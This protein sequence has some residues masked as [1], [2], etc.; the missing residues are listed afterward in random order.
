MAEI[1]QGL[2]KILKIKWKLQTAY[3]PQSSRKVECMN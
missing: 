2:A 3:R 1:A